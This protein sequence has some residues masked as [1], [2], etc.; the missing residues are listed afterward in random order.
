[1]AK[2]SYNFI[3]EKDCFVRQGWQARN[4]KMGFAIIKGHYRFYPG[5]R[6]FNSAADYKA[7]AVDTIICTP[8]GYYKPAVFFIAN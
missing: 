5:P 6:N 1:M 2:Q 3:G 8:A 7:V 4:D